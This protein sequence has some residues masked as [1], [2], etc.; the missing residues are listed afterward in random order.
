M[1]QTV[2]EKILAAH[3]RDEV[4]PGKIIW[5]GIDVRTARDFAGASVVKNFRKAFPGAKADDPKKTFFT[6]DCNAPANTIAYAQNQQV[7]R[8]FARE[9]GIRVYDVDWG[10]GSHVLLEEGLALP[11]T[12]TVGTDSHLNVLGAVGAFGQ[13]MGDVDIAYVFRTGR[14]WFEVPPTMKV[15]LHGRYGFPTTAK[16]L[17]L[18]LVGRLGAR[19]ALGRAVEV[20]GSA[21]DALDLA[22]RITLASM[23]T[24]MGAIIAFLPPSDEVMEFVRALGRDDVAYPV[25][26]PDAAYEETVELDVTGLRPKISAPPNPENVHDVADL[27]GEPVHTIVVGSCTNGRYEDIRLVA[28]I[29][30]GKR[31][32]PGVVLKVSPATR[33]AWGRLLKEGWL[34]VLYDAGAVVSHPA[35]AGCAEGQIGMTGEGEVQL[36][37]GNRN[38]PGKQGKGP[39]YLCSPATAAA[40]A[41]TGTITSPERL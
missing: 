27:E 24:E 40:S 17:T 37:T 29:L 36:S 8:V 28:E 7:C 11:G 21:A 13:G 22:G 14:T 39:T 10:I 1:G 9:Q 35:C 2:I 12:T 34:E 20:T 23:A 16:D 33:R 25:P 30:K 4:A 15:V 3:S 5:L 19:G 38:F 18:A 31:V 6:F 41:L 32:A 26:D